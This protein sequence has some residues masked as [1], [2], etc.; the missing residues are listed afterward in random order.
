[1]TFHDQSRIEGGISGALAVYNLSMTAAKGCGMKGCTVSAQ[2]QKFQKDPTYKSMINAHRVRGKNMEA[3][4]PP[5]FGGTVKHMKTDHKDISNPHALAWYMYEKGDK[6][7]VKAPKG[8][9]AKHVS[10]E[11]SKKRSKALHAGGPG[12]GRKPNMTYTGKTHENPSS[13]E[14]G[15]TVEHYKDGSHEVRVTTYNTPR[16]GNS[17]RVSQYHHTNGDEEPAPEHNYFKDRAAAK[18]HLSTLGIKAQ[19]ALHAPERNRTPKGV[20]SLDA[21]NP[22]VGFHADEKVGDIQAPNKKKKR[23]AM[24]AG[25]PGSGRKPGEGASS[26]DEHKAAARYHAAMAAKFLESTQ[27]GAQQVAMDHFSAQT[28]HE[29]A[30]HLETDRHT[31]WAQQASGR[32]NASE[33]NF[34]AGKFSHVHAGKKK[35]KKVKANMPTTTTKLPNDVM[36]ES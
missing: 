21:D 22:D 14:H 35:R 20:N 32:A 5:G 3:V 11:V 36:E 17:V 12:S 19:G 31:H 28:A 4:S 29:N 6:S 16:G 7:H 15:R 2:W 9:G 26:K 8:T 1:M 23:K 27:N 34:T 24:K 13:S 30:A 25:G 18:E 10:K 33:E